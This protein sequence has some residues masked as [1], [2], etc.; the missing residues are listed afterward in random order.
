MKS[1]SLHHY[2]VSY[3]YFL[4]FQYPL[5]HHSIKLKHVKMAEDIM[6][7]IQR[8]LHASQTPWQKAC[9]TSNVSVSW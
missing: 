2:P 4:I 7:A 1:L 6:L 8:L 3:T 9:Q 5:I